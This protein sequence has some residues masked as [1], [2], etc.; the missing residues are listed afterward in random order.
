MQQDLVPGRAT[1]KGTRRYAERFAG[2]RTGSDGHFRLPDGVRLSSLGMGT[3]DGDPGGADELLYRSA[4]PRALERGA[5]VFDT[6]LSYRAQEAERTL[7]VALRRWLAEGKAQRDEIYVITKGGYLTYDPRLVRTTHE[8][9]R[10]LVETYVESGL[11]DPSEVV[12]GTHCL[13]PRFLQDQIERSR[14]N[15]GLD[16]IDLYCLQ[17]PELQLHGRGPDEFKSVLARAF[18]TLE[19][20]A[21]DGRISAYGISTW[22]GL[23]IPYHARGHLSVLEVFE[24][25]LDVG[26]ADHHLRGVQLPYSLALGD[27]AAEA[28]Q[29]GPT[30]S[31][32]SVLEELRDTGTAV[33]AISPLVRGRATRG[34]P[35]FVRD[36]FPECRSDAQRCL[37]FARSSPG[38]TSAIVGMRQPEHV[39]ENLELTF[40]D[41]ASPETI[42]R[43]FQR[44]LG[45]AG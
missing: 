3:R 30:G 8:A 25:A 32:Q 37:Q 41:P 38:V 17:E 1:S 43:L 11:V 14:R 33:F 7:G 16:T 40:T 20:A 24:L 39:D 35:P 19:V 45:R 12:N 42:E 4:I 34:L 22:S 28:S 5:N 15:L 6:A 27:A 36:A 26:G 9:R 13:G 29:F 2:A 23:L 31:A 10:Y 18:E 44:V 21:A